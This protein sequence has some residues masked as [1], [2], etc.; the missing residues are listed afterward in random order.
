MMLI[1]D[2]DEDD[3]HGSDDDAND[4]AHDDVRAKNGDDDDFLFFPGVPVRLVRLLLPPS[5][6]AQRGA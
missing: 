1:H 4:V 6:E 3:D 2:K 5:A